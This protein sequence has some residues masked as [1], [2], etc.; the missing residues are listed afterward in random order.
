M[1]SEIKEKKIGKNTYLVSQFG[2]KTGRR[3]LF[4]LTKM[5]GPTIAGLIRGGGFSQGGIAGALRAFAESGSDEDIDYLCDSF[6]AVT[7]VK[8]PL[9]NG[10][11]IELDLGKQFDD[12][13]RGHY[14][15]MI[16]WLMFAIEY[17]FESFLSE[18][19]NEG[20]G[21]G[22]MLGIK[23]TKSESKSPPE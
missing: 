23:R 2:A 18:M 10:H 11:E 13:F 15:E 21:L 17:N 22:E 16:A 4:R 8:T 12:H 1:A 3:V 19:T 5:L 9:A 14:G 7:K 20:S 6:A